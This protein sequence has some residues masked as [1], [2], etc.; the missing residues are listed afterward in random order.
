MELGGMRGWWD[1][2]WGRKGWREE[3]ARAH[4]VVV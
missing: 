2:G 3:K 4:V 1:W